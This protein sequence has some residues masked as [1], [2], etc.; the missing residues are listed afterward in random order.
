MLYLIFVIATMMWGIGMANENE[1]GKMTEETVDTE[2][3][4]HVS[5]EGDGPSP[6]EASHAVSVLAGQDRA[7]SETDEDEESKCFEV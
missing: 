1:G 6:R 7:N 4:D 5:D 3:F 2:S